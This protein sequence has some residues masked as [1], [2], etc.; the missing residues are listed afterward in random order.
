MEVGAS[1]EKFGMEEAKADDQR[2]VEVFTKAGP[3]W[4]TWTTGGLRQ[5]ARRG[6]QTRPGRISRRRS[7]TASALFDMALSVK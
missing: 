3:R 4:S 2:V 1:L 6:E 5:V 7:R